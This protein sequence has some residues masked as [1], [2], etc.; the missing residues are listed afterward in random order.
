MSLREIANHAK[1][2]T[3]TVSRVINGVPTVNRN[4]AKRV[5]KAIGEHGYSG[6]T[7]AR[8]LVSG[9]SRL[10]GLVI[11]DMRDPFF[12]E[13]VQSFEAAAIEFGCEA[14]VMSTLH[15]PKRIELSVRRM[16]ERRIEGAAVLTFGSEEV[17]L[18]K[19]RVQ[20]IAAVFV[21]VEPCRSTASVVQIDYKRGTRHAVQ[22]LAA[23]RHEHI[24]YVAGP[25]HSKTALAK[26][27]A[28]E[29]SMHE[30][31]LDVSSELMVAG[32]DTVEGGMRALTLFARLQDRPTAIVC[33]TDMAAVGVM[34]QAHEL[35]MAVPQELSV[36][37]FD[38]IP[39]AGFVTPP[40]TTV[41]VPKAELARLAFRALICELNPARD[42]IYQPQEY[43][44]NTDLVLRRSTALACLRRSGLTDLQSLEA[45][46]AHGETFA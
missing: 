25:A 38:D 10:F 41:I 42:E 9:K 40:L 2:S 18:E 11:S 13:I 44:L 5:Q 14:L 34:K 39:L 7:Q 37:G 4:L 46:S 21:D 36:I 20:G 19:L 35:G 23:L 6:N 27:S 12:P 8:C 16:V 28:F 43:L 17:I 31:S 30:I 1:V 45:N 33:S 26:R 24:G 32:D 29:E 22:H 3:A 15:D